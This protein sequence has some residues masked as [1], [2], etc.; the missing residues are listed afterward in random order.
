MPAYSLPKQQRLLSYYFLLTYFVTLAIASESISFSHAHAGNWKTI[1][2]TL[3]ALLCYGALYLLPAILITKLALFLSNLGERDD[4]IVRVIPAYTAAVLTTGITNL[5]LYANAKIFSLYGMFINGFIINLVMTPGGIESL[6]GSSAS[7]LGF[8][9][10]ALGFLV[11]QALVLWGTREFYK[12]RTTGSQYHILPKATFLHVS[13]MLL[14]STMG[15]HFSYAASEAFNHHGIAMAAE[16]IPFFQPVSARHL[17]RKLGFQVEERKTMD[18]PGRLTYP[19]NPL[20]ISQPAKP[21]NIVWLASESWRADMLDPEI[22]PA[23]WQFASQ[24]G[25]FTRNYSGGN[26]TRNGVFT[27]FTGIPG[28][29]WFKFIKEQRGA[30]II[31]VLQKQGY[32]MDLFTSARFS[33]PEFDKTIFSKIPHEKLHSLDAGGEGWERDRKNVTQLLDFID[34]RD[35]SKPFFTF[36]F[37]E[38]P[39]ARYYF[40]P[41]S[42]I[43]RPY[44]DDINYATLDKEELRKDIIPIKNRYINAVHHL[45]SQ[46]AR[47]FSYLQKKNLLDS[48]IVILVGD[49][50]EEFMEHGYWGHNSTFV[51][52]Q[53]RTPLVIWIPG[54]VPRVDDRMTSHMDIIPTIMPLLGVTNPSSDYATGFDL[55]SND[56]RTHTYI[57]DWSRIVY[58]DDEAKIAQPISIQ[59]YTGSQVSS[60]DDQ[61]LPSAQEEAILKKKQPEMLQMVQ[62]LS[63]FLDKNHH[64]IAAK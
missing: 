57:S 37:F 22:M 12:R 23:S 4:A 30:A 14:A 15:V 6:G 31:D 11:F 62:D 10:I 46:F 60:A 44:R 36:M 28:N 16:T 20:N 39:H 58:V 26:G 21:L 38:S 32:Q 18:I 43:R 7:E 49:H 52:Q 61:T 33:Y 3:F 64:K 48:T 8:A 27:M 19:L 9:I 34:Q 53:V 51:D 1:A 45:D 63:R 41:E 25:R 59:G 24:A 55:M 29:Y 56:R 50:G 2:F 13:I 35:P 54:M 47:I 17:F 40:P 42:I 5:L